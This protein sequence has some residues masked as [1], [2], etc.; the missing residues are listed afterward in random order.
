MK[1]FD[2]DVAVDY[3][4]AGVEVPGESAK[5]S[6]FLLPAREEIPWQQ[7]KP[8]VIVCPGGGYH[9]LSERESGPI[10]MRFLSAGMHAAILRYHVAPSRYP[11]AALEL[12]WC[13]QQ[14]RRHAE[15]WHIKPDQIY[16]AGFSAGGHLCCTVGTTWDW[17][18]FHE[19]LDGDVS[20][21]P[22]GQILSYPVVTLGDHTHMGSRNSLLGEKATDPAWLEKL[23]LENQVTEKTVPT[24][25]WHTMDDELV[26]VE[27][28]LQYAAALRRAGVPFEMHIYESGPHGLATCDITTATEKR[29][30]APD[31]ANWMEMAVRFIARRNEKK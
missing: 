21:R 3:A 17:P 16:I 28:S 10:A 19:A 13:V 5:L 8:L 7:E 12:A 1:Y 26:P 27:N 24:F 29:K 15:E 14:C 22:D 20:W 18:V 30:P 31:C 2:I 4:R 9:F 25:L 11:T 23:S 6:C